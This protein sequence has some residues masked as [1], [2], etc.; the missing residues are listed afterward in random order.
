MIETVN[1][2]NTER[3]TQMS[4][5]NKLERELARINAI[6]NKDFKMLKPKRTRQR[7][8]TTLLN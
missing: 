4:K 7:N 2:K 8:V 3:Q 1:V 6:M 5:L